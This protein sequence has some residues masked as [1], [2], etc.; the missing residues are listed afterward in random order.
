MNT[1]PAKA[2]IEALGLQPHPEGGYFREVYR[3]A[4]SIPRAVLP[5][6]FQGGDRPY[7]TSIYFLL[8]STA[9]SRLHRIASDE[10]WHFYTGSSLRIHVILPTG[11]Y[12]ALRLGINLDQGEQLQQ[13][14]PA[15]AWFGATVDAPD[16]FSLVGCTVAPGFDFRDFELGDRQQLQQQFPQHQRLI[17]RLTP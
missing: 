11:E 7:C 13:V 9:C 16:S 4:G 15:G 6:G 8:P 2:W 1:W 3:S 17:E 12:Q 10:L 14:V 5:S